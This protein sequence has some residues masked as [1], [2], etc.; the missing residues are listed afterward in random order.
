MNGTPEQQAARLPSKSPDRT[1][2]T[3]MISFDKGK[4][5]QNF[6]SG[7]PFLKKHTAVLF[8]ILTLVVFCYAGWIFFQYVYN[9]DIDNDKLNLRT[10]EFNQELYETVLREI[11]EREKNFQE[12]A[13]ETYPDPFR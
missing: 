1:F 4:I 6:L 8:M 7:Y 12:G 9:I 2:I 10:T 11:K 13:K 5:Y 3:K